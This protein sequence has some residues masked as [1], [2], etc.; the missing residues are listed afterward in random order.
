MSNVEIWTNRGWV[1]FAQFTQATDAV[2]LLPSMA[3]HAGTR[4]R[5]TTDGSVIGA[6][7]P[8]GVTSE[9]QPCSNSIKHFVCNPSQH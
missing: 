2:R 9:Q 6:D 8:R 7:V 5:C 1:P 4:V 3:R